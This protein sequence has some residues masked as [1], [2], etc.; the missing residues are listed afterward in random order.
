MKNYIKRA[1]TF[2]AKLQDEDIYLYQLL[3]HQHT[4]KI[5]RVIEINGADGKILTEN[6]E[7]FLYPRIKSMITPLNLS[8]SK[9]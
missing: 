4:G 8:V 3:T 7:I 1:K 5:A 9:L 2:I 6:E